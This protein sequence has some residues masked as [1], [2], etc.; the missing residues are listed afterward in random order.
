[1]E[2]IVQAVLS[3]D[4]QLRQDLNEGIDFHVKR[5]STVTGKDYRDLKSLH[6]SG[7]PDICAQRTKIKAFSFQR[8]YG[9][10]ASAIA[11][12]TGMPIDDVKDL[13]IAENLTYPGLN[14][15][16]MTV[17]GSINNS[18]TITQDKMFFDGRP[19]QIAIGEWFSPTGTRYVWSEHEAQDWQKERGRLTSF[20]PTERKNWPVQ[21][22]G[23]EIVQTMMGKL[24]R[25][26]VA[27]QNFGGKA[28]LVNTV[29]DCVLID[30]H[31][32]VV[33]LVIPTAKQILEAVPYYFNKQF[34]MGID[35]PFPV[36]AEIGP[37]W[38]E[39]KHYER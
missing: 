11:D 30:V 37:N 13:I 27:K 17:S 35:V 20:S 8:A 2:I 19:H 7:D 31:Q 29:H 33:D 4:K 38:Y 32:D 10:G 9:A 34:D 25:W 23:G 5:L 39:M 18:R 22:L 12:S 3:G 28:Y 15:F 6:L 21:G 26:F 1:L 14:E 36:E 24:W 16:D